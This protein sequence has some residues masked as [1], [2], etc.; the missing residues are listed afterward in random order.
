MKLIKSLLTLAIIASGLST[1]AQNG[2]WSGSGGG[3]GYQ[4]LSP[5]DRAYNQTKQMKKLLTLSKEQFEKVEIIN[6]K[7]AMMMDSTMKA[8]GG[9]SPEMREKMKPMME[10]KDKELKPILTE[11]QMKLYEENKKKMYQQGGGR[12]QN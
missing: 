1:Y 8:N 12:P 7:Y 6:V 3:G 4:Q 9:F 11:E 10:A 2:Q 5:E